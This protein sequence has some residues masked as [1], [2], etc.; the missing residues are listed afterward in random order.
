MAD[1]EFHTDRKQFDEISVEQILALADPL[2]F[3]VVDALRAG[4]PMSVRELANAIGRPCKSLYY[5]IRKLVAAG[6]VWKIGTRM[7][8]RRDESVYSVTSRSRRLP[9]ITAQ[10]LPA[11]QTLMRC[12]ARGWERDVLAAQAAAAAGSADASALMIVRASGRLSVED[13]RTVAKMSE[14]V[15]QFV[16][17]RSEGPGP[18]LKL[19]ISLVPTVPRGTGSGSRPAD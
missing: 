19:A 7:D 3:E 14:D 4:T 10:S 8:G 9:S 18:V 1:A 12:V 2:R 15:A 17:D 5:P 16:R 6:L 13:R 11:L